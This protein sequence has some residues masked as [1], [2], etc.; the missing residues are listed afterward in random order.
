MT[1]GRLSAVH[2]ELVKA[3]ARFPEVAAER[4]EELAELL[5]R[6]G[7][8]YPTAAVA[9][10]AALGP[11]AGDVGE[12]ALRRCVAEGVH[13]SVSAEAAVALWPVV[14]S[15]TSCTATPCTPITRCAPPSAS[16]SRPPG[17]S[18]DVNFP[19]RKRPSSERSL[20]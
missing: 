10:L 15:R 4:V 3:L 9:V 8:G 19:P 12:R 1:T 6:H 2:P 5:T 13:S 11:A 20:L 17:W 14:R 16:S 18:A 7:T